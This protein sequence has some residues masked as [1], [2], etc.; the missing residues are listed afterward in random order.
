MT[1]ATT[2]VP[3]ILSSSSGSSDRENSD[4]ATLLLERITPEVNRYM[5]IRKKMD[6]PPLAAIEKQTALDMVQPSGWYKIESEEDLKRRSDNR[7]PRAPHPLSYIELER[8]GFADSL[9]E[10]IMSLGGPHMVGRLLDI[11][12]REPEPEK[13]DENLKPVREERYA[14][15]FQGSLKLGAALEDDMGMTFHLAL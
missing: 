3:T 11:D 5:S 8:H 1:R 15:D 10:P 13:W 9:M 7:L 6:L 4:K 14:L 2:K 12:W